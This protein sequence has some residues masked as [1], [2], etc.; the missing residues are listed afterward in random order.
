VRNPLRSEAEAF[1]L[2]LIVVVGLGLIALGAWINTWVGVAVALAEALLGGWVLLF[3]STPSEA[4]VAEAPAPSPPGEHRVLVVANEAV[5]APELLQRLR[6]HAAGNRLRVLVVV[7]VPADPKAQ[8]T[9]DEGDAREVAERRLADSLASMRSAGL[10]A[11]G[12]IGEIDPVQA[13]E[14]AVRT[15]APDEL[16]VSTHPE[17]RMSPFEEALPE[18]LAERFAMPMTHVVVELDADLHDS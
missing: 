14:D 6:D 5:G 1:R 18:R 16:I 17:G 9:G 15:F 7:P 8:W 13:V 10:E 3:R 11:Q 4:P 12:Q 2:V